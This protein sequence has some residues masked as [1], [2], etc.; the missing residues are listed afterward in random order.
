MG[1]K[2][3]QH[4][5]AY[6]SQLFKSRFDGQHCQP[7]DGDPDFN[8]GL[9]SSKSMRGGMVTGFV[10]AA[11]PDTQTVDVDTDEGSLSGCRIGTSYIGPQGSGHSVVYEPGTHV[12]VCLDV[13]PPVVL[14]CIAEAD[15]GDTSQ[16]AS[17]IDAITCG[18]KG[19]G[20]DDPVYVDQGGT[21]HRNGR[22]T[23]LM[24]GDQLFS[25][26]EGNLVGILRGL[27]VLKGSEL[28]QLVMSNLGGM[29]RMVSNLYQHFHAAGITQISNKN[30]KTTASFKYGTTSRGDGEVE[31]TVHLTIGA[32]GDLVELLITTED[33]EKLSRFHLNSEG[34]LEMEVNDIEIEVN[35]D[36]EVEIDGDFQL[37]T[38][39]NRVETVGGDCSKIV[40]G[41][42]GLSCNEFE[43]RS[44]GVGRIQ[45]TR[46]L[47]L[48]SG[49]RFSQ[50]MLGESNV[51]SA[52]YTHEAIL[53]DIEI[54]T[55]AAGT[56][57]A[58]VS[59]TKAGDVDVSGVRNGTF[60]G[61]IRTTITGTSVDLGSGVV[62]QPVI[63]NTDLSP[64]FDALIAYLNVA[65]TSVGGKIVI[66][67]APVSGTPIGAAI[68]LAGSKIVRSS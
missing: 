37:K 3:M 59:L 43:L 27:S 28:S 34:D 57:L 52:K 61:K 2:R 9:I 44:G 22:T 16:D 41:K 12:L 38:E 15:V 48:V 19:F 10:V 26:S 46:D 35:K 55:T 30:G 50:Q 65:G 14:T 31:S 66:P 18:T 33:G 6:S 56:K 36:L 67:P 49:G 32:E 23:Q 8:D 45:S 13:S 17:K 58:G 40:D 21:N 47:T 68:A 60:G 63:R 54:S 20:G 25:A 64:I 5:D 53:N 62:R 1:S 4:G 11:Y 7:G 39:G 29:V 24:P 42:W 51:K